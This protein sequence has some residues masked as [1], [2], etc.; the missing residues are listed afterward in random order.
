[1]VLNGVLSVAGFVLVII[2][3]T[4]R[5]ESA[6][7]ED[8]GDEQAGGTDVLGLLQTLGLSALALGLVGLAALVTGRNVMYTYFAALF[9][10]IV[11]GFWSGLM[12]LSHQDAWEEELEME[13]SKDWDGTF[14][15]VVPSEVQLAANRS[16]AEN[17]GCYRAY[18]HRCWQIVKDEFATT[19]YTEAGLVALALVALMLGALCSAHRMIG[20]DAIVRKT[21][22]LLAHIGLISGW[23]LIGLAFTE[24]ELVGVSLSN[25]DI[26]GVALSDVILLAGLSLSLLSVWSYLNLWLP[27]AGRHFLRASVRGRDAHGCELRLHPEGPSK[28]HPT[29]WGR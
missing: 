23:L 17:G 5:D 20:A 28:G 27:K 3:S 8:G 18:T 7:A 22:L 26:L 25:I 21:E 10:T 19:F 1:M 12:A 9:L 24:D 6:A 14:G 2:A 11:L 16:E 4:A 29:G 15:L 13:A